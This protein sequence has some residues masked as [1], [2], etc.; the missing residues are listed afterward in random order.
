MGLTIRKV[1]LLMV[2][3][4]VATFAVGITATLL[5]LSEEWHRSLVT[6][7]AMAVSLG[8]V[9]HWTRAKSGRPTK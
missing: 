9:F 8:F 5:D 4:A 3:A 2:V 1:A 7:T 6:G